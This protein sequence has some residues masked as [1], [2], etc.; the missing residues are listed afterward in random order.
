[1]R[2][3]LNTSICVFTLTYTPKAENYILDTFNKSQHMFTR[4][5]VRMKSDVA[6]KE[7]KIHNEL[8]INDNSAEHLFLPVIT[9]DVSVVG[10][11]V[12]FD[13]NITQN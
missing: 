11:S 12:T 3:V 9:F 8:N 7:K 5:T 13:T 1:M 2:G 10:G 4:M 6:A